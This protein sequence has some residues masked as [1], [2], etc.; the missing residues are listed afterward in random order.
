MRPAKVIILSVIALLLF[1][2]TSEAQKTDIENSNVKSK[3][4]LI[5]TIYDPCE[6]PEKP[7]VDEK[8]NAQIM[9]IFEQGESQK[10]NLLPI[11]ERVVGYGKLLLGKPYVDKT[12][13]VNP[14]QERLVC[15]LDGLD[16]VTFFENAWNF[17]R[18]SHHPLEGR[19]ECG[20]SNLRY[21]DG[22]LD[23]YASRLHYT[24]DYFYNNAKRGNLKEMTTSI[25]GI[26]AVIED[27]PIDFM[28]NHP[29]SY[30]QIE[31]NEAEWKRIE[32]YEREMANRGG[33]YYIK[34]EN[35]AK[36]E[37]GM[38]DGDLIGI[39]TS[40]KGI[41]CSHTGIAVRGDDGRIH[42]MHASLTKKKVIISD[43]PLADYLAGNS[44][45]TGIIVYRP[46]EV[47][48]K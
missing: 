14:D 45:Q 12:L 33:F 13:E 10:L 39:T 26:Y 41:D 46:L 38:Q 36:I 19:F 6:G 35:V 29:A 11:G 17:A 1:S 24:T 42:L 40:I 32:F 21:R 8:T 27:K 30:K 15:N 7:K 2:C 47:E 18:L 3:V 4:N 48:K 25:G 22:K 5:R 37:K 44:K 23:G 31:N 28:S 16:C 43:E 9:A 34:K 20:L